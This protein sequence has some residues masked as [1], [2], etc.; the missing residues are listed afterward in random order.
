M[1]MMMMKTRRKY[2]K[3]HSQNDYGSE[4]SCN[5]FRMSQLATWQSNCSLTLSSTDLNHR[6]I[7]TPIFPLSSSNKTL[8]RWRNTRGRNFSC[9]YKPIYILIRHRGYSR[10]TQKDN[11]KRI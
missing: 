8:R 11:Q 7:T 6:Y 5:S 9:V 2:E 3:T 10:L 1:M 4:L